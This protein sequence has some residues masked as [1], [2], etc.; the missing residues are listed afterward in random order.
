MT[1]GW[2]SPS[3]DH[4]GSPRSSRS[5]GARDQRLGTRDRATSGWTSP[6]VDQGRRQVLRAP[7]IGDSGPAT[8]PYPVG[9]PHPMITATSRHRARRPG[10]LHQPQRPQAPPHSPT[11]WRPSHSRQIS[12]TCVPECAT[13]RCVLLV[14][15]ARRLPRRPDD[16]GCAG[17]RPRVRAGTVADRDDRAGHA[18]VRPADDGFL[19]RRR[20]GVRRGVRRGLAR[21]GGPG[22]ADGPHRTHPSAA[23]RRRAVRGGRRRPGHGDRDRRS[24][25]RCW[26]ASPCCPDWS[27]PRCPVPPARCG[28]CSCRPDR[29][30]TRPTATRRSAWRS[31]SSS[32][33]PS[34]CSWSWPR[35]RVPAWWWPR[36][37]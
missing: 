18:A 22:P 21:L 17:P 7:E 27:S 9:R 35:G 34:R 15:L 5:H 1:C 13:L 36:P 14:R 10:R 28:G 32:G 4:G 19:R 30:G 2:T 8:V 12:G 25:C 37:R 16:A 33:P 11:A 23:A 24:R 26:W 20:T 29:D 31:S 3:E 6:A